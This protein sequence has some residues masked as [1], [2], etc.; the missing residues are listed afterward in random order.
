MSLLFKI[1]DFLMYSYASLTPEN[2]VNM[3]DMPDDGTSDLDKT[4]E[5]IEK[6]KV[7][8]FW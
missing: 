7:Y 4:A 5:E 2:G 8:P 1:I 6:N 3:E